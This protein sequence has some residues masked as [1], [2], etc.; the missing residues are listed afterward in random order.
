VKKYIV[1]FAVA[2]IVAVLFL[3]NFAYNPELPATNTIPLPVAF[4]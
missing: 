3:I 1:G 4:E 2:I